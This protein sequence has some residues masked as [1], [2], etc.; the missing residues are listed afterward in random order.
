MNST[1]R[2]IREH[3]GLHE[4]LLVQTPHTKR[5]DRLR[6]SHSYECVAPT[7]HQRMCRSVRRPRNLR[8]W[9]SPALET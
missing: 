5:G 4:T 8:M 9:A 7:K 2:R 1:S 6:T 3:L